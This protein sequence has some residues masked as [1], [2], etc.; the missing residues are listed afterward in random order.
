VEAGLI[1]VEAGLSVVEAVCGGGLAEWEE[2]Q[3]CFYTGYEKQK[4]G[5]GSTHPMGNS[6]HEGEDSP[7]YRILM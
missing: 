5:G 6:S 4:K 3:V 7:R 2:Q 1:V